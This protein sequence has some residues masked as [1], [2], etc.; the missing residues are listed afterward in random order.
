MNRPAALRVVISGASFG[1]GLALARH[2]LERGATL[3]VLARR[4]EPLQ[5]LAAE[6][7]GFPLLV[8]TSRKSF[9]GKILGDAPVDKR[10]PGSLSSAAVAV[11]NGAKIVRVHDVRETVETLKVVEAIKNWRKS[12][13]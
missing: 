11:W 9:L 8:G 10:S 13:D 4:I 2:Y 12:D 3:A 6:F 7:P 5:I 1:L